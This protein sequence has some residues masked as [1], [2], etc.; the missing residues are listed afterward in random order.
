MIK[1]VAGQLWGRVET[2]SSDVSSVPCI[3]SDAPDE[4]MF[5]LQEQ[6]N[7]RAILATAAPEGIG[8]KLIPN[9]LYKHTQAG[10]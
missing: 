6:G 8:L 5:H 7:E 3:D 9:F 4:F 2:A 10:S 1:R